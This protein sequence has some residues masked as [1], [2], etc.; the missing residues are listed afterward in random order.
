MELP[1]HGSWWYR[2]NLWDSWSCISPS[3]GNLFFISA[4]LF[5]V[6][7]IIKEKVRN[8]KVLV[9]A[10]NQIALPL[11]RYVSLFF[12]RFGTLVIRK[13]E[14]CSC[15]LIRLAITG[16]LWPFSP[17]GIWQNAFLRTAGSAVGTSSACF[18]FCHAEALCLITTPKHPMEYWLPFR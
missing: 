8:I 9:S 15:G 3:K 14:T 13:K 12:Y 6:L 16:L 1:P 4:C 5:P 7:R 17:S 11:W 18:L 2:P 10:W